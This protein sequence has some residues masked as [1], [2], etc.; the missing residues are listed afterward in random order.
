MHFTFAVTFVEVTKETVN[1]CGCDRCGALLARGGGGACEVGGGAGGGGGGEGAEGGAPG[2][3]RRRWQSCSCNTQGH[4][5]VRVAQ[6]L[7]L[8][9]FR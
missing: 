6:G 7:A 8:K 1:K 5:E 3:G 2:R 4:T 9:H